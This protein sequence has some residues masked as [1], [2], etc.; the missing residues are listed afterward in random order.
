MTK[1]DAH[2][3]LVEQE[4][5]SYIL[6]HKNETADKTNHYLPQFKLY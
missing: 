4:I 5:R 2:T 1:H 3:D 6:Q